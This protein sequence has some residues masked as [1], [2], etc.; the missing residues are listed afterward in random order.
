[1][2]VIDQAAG[3]LKMKSWGVDTR[4]TAAGKQSQHMF[5][6]HLPKKK[7]DYTSALTAGAGKYVQ[8]DQFRMCLDSAE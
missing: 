7:P 2:M 6:A 4:V 1:M 3:D 8:V 5:D